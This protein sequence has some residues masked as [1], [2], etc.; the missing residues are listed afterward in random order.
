VTKA[1][2]IA[3]NLAVALLACEWTPQAL[4]IETEV[5]L[6][7]TTRKSQA[8]LLKQLTESVW[9]K[10]P[11]TQSWLI[12]FF[13]K[14]RWFRAAASRLLKQ[15]A[16][17]PAVLTPPRFAPSPRFAGLEIPRITTLGDLALWLRL[18]VEQ[19]DWFADDKRQHGRTAIPI[20][21]HYTYSFVAKASGPPRLIEA[22]KPRLKTMQRRILH[23]ILDQLPAHDAAHGFVAGRS[24]LTSAAVHAGE[25]VVITV[26]LKDFFTTTR[27]SRVHAMFR[28]LGY[29]WSV[30]RALTALASTMTPEAVFQRLPRERRHD[31]RTRRQFTE[32]H[33][34][35]GAPTSP[36]LANLAA[37]QLDARL[38]GFAR[39]NGAAYTRYADDLAFSGDAALADKADWFVRVLGEI[40]EDEG[41]ALNPAKTRIM[42]ANGCQRITGLVVNEHINV[43]RADFDQLKATL[44]NCVKLGPAG[45]NRDGHND[46]RAHLDGRVGW[47][48][49]VNPARGM[50]L[51]QMFEAIAW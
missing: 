14:S 29:P 42:R 51:R 36:A 20:L 43:G 22:P 2:W 35:Q 39:R 50:K 1:S 21:Q 5:Q 24:V 32:P 45:Q 31:W 25:A 30:A 11:P 49:N 18:P 26:D 23:D 7:P 9:G 48:E 4:R 33:L 8:R 40:A 28:A 15:P 34:P 17:I 10:V 6:G 13:L 19:F 3:R 37:W 27:L 47:V 46:F 16:P 41:F 12:N 44:H 38:A